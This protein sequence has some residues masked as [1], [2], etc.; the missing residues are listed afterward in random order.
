MLQFDFDAGNE[1]AVYPF[2]GGDATGLTDDGAEVALGE[3][4]PLG[5]EGYLMLMRGVLVDEIDEAVKNGLFAGYD[6]LQTVV[7]LVV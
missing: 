1:R 4:H 7:V 6:T 3:A 2:F 5:I